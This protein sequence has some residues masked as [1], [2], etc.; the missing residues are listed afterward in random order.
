MGAKGPRALEIE[1]DHSI[2]AAP[3]LTGMTSDRKQRG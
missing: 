1:V 2:M 3:A